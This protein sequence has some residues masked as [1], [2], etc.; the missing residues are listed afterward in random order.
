MHEFALAQDIVET[1]ARNVGDEMSKLDVIHMEVGQ[2]SGAVI[3][4]LEF[5]LK[6]ILQEKNLPAV[7]INI[8]PVPAAA[9][10]DCKTEY[11]LDSIMTACPSCGSFQRQ[12][13]SGK[14]VI[15]KS[16]ELKD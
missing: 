11:E 7:K 3:D 14:D 12:I 2:F 16:I 8:V 6:I 13:T 1:I 5:G 4:S 10:C 9:I 15:I